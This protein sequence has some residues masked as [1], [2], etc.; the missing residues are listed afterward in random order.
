MRYIFHV[1]LRKDLDQRQ[2]SNTCS[3]I[4]K[5]SDKFLGAHRISEDEIEVQITK[6]ESF[7]R[8]NRMAGQVRAIPVISEV[9]ILERKI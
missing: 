8:I 7:D 6:D 5:L 4:L 9:E 1:K 3:D 2:K